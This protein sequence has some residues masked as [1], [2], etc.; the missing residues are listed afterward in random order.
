MKSKAAIPMKSSAHL[1]F[2]TLLPDPTFHAAAPAPRTSTIACP[3]SAG[4]STTR[5]P[6]AFKADIFS[7]AVPLPPEM[8]APA[9]PIRRPGGAVWPAMKRRSASSRCLRRSRRLPLRRFRRSRRSSRSHRSRVIV[10]EK[11]KSIDDASC[12]LS[13][14]RRCR[15]RSIAQARARSTAD[16]F[17]GQR[18]GT[19]YDADAA[20]LMDVAGH[21]ADL[22][23][24]GRDH[25][26]NSGR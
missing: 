25:P 3:I 18:A 13:G 11:F 26:G 20:F 8:I 7:A 2:L 23:F 6:A 22:A 14:R 12:R 9:W 17:I 19:R 16:R 24:A 5:I 21:D 10:L 4:D 1:L 15:W